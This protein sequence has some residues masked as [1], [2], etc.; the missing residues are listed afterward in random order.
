MSIPLGQICSPNMAP[1]NLQMHPVFQDKKREEEN[2]FRMALD[3]YND[4]FPEIIRLPKPQFVSALEKYI[5]ISQ[6]NPIQKNIF[7]SVMDKILREYYE[8]DYIFINQLISKLTSKNCKPIE[9]M[10]FI[11]HCAKTVKLLHTCKSVLFDLNKNYLICL[12][13]KQI[14]NKKCALLFCEECN[15]EYYSSVVDENE[16]KLYKP[17]TWLKYHCASMINDT[18]KCKECKGVLYINMENHKLK[19]RNCKYERDQD[20]FDWK[21]LVCKE[22]FKSEAKVYN[23]LEFK[24]IKMKIKQTIFEGIPAFPYHMECRCIRNED[25]NQY[26]FFHKKECNGLLF[27][28]NL[29]KRKIVVCGR[30]RLLNFY[31]NHVWT[32]PLCF[33]RF[34]LLVRIPVPSRGKSQEKKRKITEE[35]NSNEKEKFYPDDKFNTP[36]NIRSSRGLY[37]ISGGSKEDLNSP[38]NNLINLIRKHSMSDKDNNFSNEALRHKAEVL[39]YYSKKSSNYAEEREEEQRDGNI[40]INLN[41]CVNIN[42][43]NKGI[44]KRNSCFIIN[45]NADININQSPILRKLNSGKIP[46]NQFQ[47]G[48]LEFNPDDYSVEAQIGQGTFGKIFKVKSNGYYYAMK[49]ILTSTPEETAALEKEYKIVL[50]MQSYHLNLIK[51][52][53][54]HTRKL[55]ITTYAVYVLMELAIGDWEKEIQ[56]RRNKNQYYTEEE[57]IKITKQL[58]YTFAELQKHGI[59]HRDIKPQNILITEDNSFKI[60]DFGEAKTTLGRN[61]EDTVTQTIRGTELYMSPILFK[62]LRMG[63]T[64]FTTEHNAFKSDVFSLGFCI[65]YAATLS[66]NSL[67]QI[68]ELTD[69]IAIKLVLKQYLGRRYSSRLLDIIYM[70]IEVEEKNRKDFI[71]LENYTRNL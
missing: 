23:P 32:C 39:D 66:F 5:Q 36:V 30:C 41:V 35:E 20:E 22:T 21:C 61:T 45:P 7:K 71:E 54:M 69:M 47:V 25:I 43:S 49:K 15:L 14:Y 17:A 29:N 13:C 18:M 3:E 44:K 10:I 16:D 26:Q 6:R 12:K 40:N 27:E 62:A 1:R 51:I 65:T 31:E 52:Y 48:K 53:G 11:P 24:L 34:K 67:C 57:L 19:C 37:N 68:R 4:L 70:M 50:S 38:K 56:T 28:G 46:E 42:N 58:V 60:A 59:S 55:D 9:E 33:K 63:N 2:F 8:K 64:D